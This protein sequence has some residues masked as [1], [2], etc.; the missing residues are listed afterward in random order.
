MANNRLEA[1]EVFRRTQGQLQ[2]TEQEGQK[3][4]QA[5]TAHPVQNGHEARTGSRISLSVRNFGTL[6]DRSG[7]LLSLPITSLSI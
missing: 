2:Q 6:L 4:E 7:M 1:L 5:R 3:Q